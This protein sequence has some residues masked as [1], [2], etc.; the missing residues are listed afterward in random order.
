MIIKFILF[1]LRLITNNSRLFR[2][3]EMGKLFSVLQIVCRRRWNGLTTCFWQ[4]SYH[5]F[6]LRFLL[7]TTQHSCSMQSTLVVTF[8]LNVITCLLNFYFNLFHFILCRIF[9]IFL[10]FSGFAWIRFYTK[11]GKYYNLSRKISVIH[12]LDWE[13]FFLSKRFRRNSSE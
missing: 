5:Y 7:T 10:C 3:R 11:K 13:Y 8:P 4:I 6:L 9:F 1:P 2:R 12:V